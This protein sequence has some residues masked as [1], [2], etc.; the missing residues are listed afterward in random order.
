M[1]NNDEKQLSINHIINHTSFYGNRWQRIP[2]E[3][4]NLL[5]EHVLTT[6][7]LRQKLK[8]TNNSTQIITYKN[9]KLNNTYPCV[10]ICSPEE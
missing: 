3:Q 5:I 10:V 8:K 6:P 2:K 9:K 1:T 4:S 7:G